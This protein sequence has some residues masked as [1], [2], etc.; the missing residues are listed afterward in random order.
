MVHTFD[1]H[2]TYYQKHLDLIDEY[3]HHEHVEYELQLGQ[4]PMIQLMFVHLN[5]TSIN[6]VKKAMI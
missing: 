4:Y 3:H 5:K 1:H 6:L 2:D